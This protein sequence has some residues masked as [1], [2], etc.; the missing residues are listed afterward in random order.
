MSDEDKLICPNYSKNLRLQSVEELIVE[1]VDEGFT[2][3]M[4]ALLFIT[5][6]GGVS[7]YKCDNC[8]HKYS[9]YGLI[10]QLVSVEPLDKKIS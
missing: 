6:T 9:A 8:D 5:R 2:R 10:N 1:M 4:A 7:R 3:E